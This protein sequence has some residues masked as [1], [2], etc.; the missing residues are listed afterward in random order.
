VATLWQQMSAREQLESAFEHEQRSYASG[1]VD[2]VLERRAPEAAPWIAEDPSNNRSGLCDLLVG[3][4]GGLV[5]VFT[6]G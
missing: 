6:T 1:S 3:W 5:G 4:L 2:G